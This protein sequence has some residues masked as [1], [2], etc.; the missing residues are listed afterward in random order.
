MWLIPR[1]SRFCHFVPAT[2]DSSSDFPTHWKTLLESLLWRSKPSPWRTWKQRLGR[3]GWLS[4]LCGRICEPS[5]ANDFE[6]ALISSLRAS[7]VSRSALPD[8]A[9]A[10][11]TSGTYGPPSSESSMLFGPDTASLKTYRG[12]C[13]R[14][15][16]HCVRTSA[17]IAEGLRS[18]WEK[19]LRPA[20]WLDSTEAQESRFSSMSRIDWRRWAIKSRRDSLQRQNAV[21]PTSGNGCSSWPTANVPNR[22][23]E[24]DKSHRPESGGVDLQSAVRMFPTPASRDY[25]HHQDLAGRT[26]GVSLPCCV[27]TG[28]TTHGR[29]GPDSPSTNGKNRELLWN[30]PHGFMGQ[31]KDGKR[32]GGGGEFAKQVKMFTT[33]CSDDTGQRKAKYQQGGT[34][35]SKQAKGKLNAN[36]VEQLMGVPVGWTDAD[37][38]LTDCDCSATASARPRPISPAEP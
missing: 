33:P 11:K 25:R 22:G 26:G 7:P 12:S 4:T 24:P 29:P 36:W 1:N 13:P 28:R 30:T 35:L 38:G 21:R 34:P 32:Y 9:K 31:E 19:T 5:R 15:P 27:V 18:D 23:C 17:S 6:A 2:A 16:S 37:I 20:S 3:V 10:P 8:Y 14:I